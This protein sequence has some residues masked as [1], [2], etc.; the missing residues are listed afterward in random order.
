M[1][2]I[3]YNN[4]KTLYNRGY[5]A[6]VAFC[7][8]KKSVVPENRPTKDEKTAWV[9]DG[10]GAKGIFQAGAMLALSRAGFIPDVIVATSIGSLNAVSALTAR[11]GDVINFWK[12]MSVKCLLSIKP[13]RK[14]V[15]SDS[16]LRNYIEKN[17]PVDNILERCKENNIEL[18]IQTAKKEAGDNLLHTAK[19][20]TYGNAIKTFFVSQGLLDQFKQKYAYRKDIE[21]KE[22]TKNN[23]HDVV[24]ASCAIPIILP[25][26]KIDGQL[27]HDGC[28]GV[29]KPVNDG[30]IA[31][32]A[33]KEKEEKGLLF[34]ILNDS[35]PKR[36]D[37]SV[38]LK[39]IEGVSKIQKIV[40]KPENNLK[41]G[42][43]R[44]NKV[45]RNAQIFMKNGYE[46]A[47]EALLAAKLIQQDQFDQ[48]KANSPLKQK[49]KSIDLAA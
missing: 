25:A 3:L 2:T 27:Y 5:A 49:N 23:V 40:I 20:H 28:I 42:I 14:G 15:C 9:L 19:K 7:R 30:Y 22:L 11:T 33:L 29:N 46:R 31:L 35:N 39:E 1:N 43:F 24:M 13:D 47:L 37:T 36:I 16:N 34:V 8:Q 12:N 32:N 18:V 26:Q 6:N 10:G 4:Q 17:V 48:L 38:D 45:G 44:F 21:V 41:T